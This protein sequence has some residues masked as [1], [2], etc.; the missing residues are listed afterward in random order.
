MHADDQ[1]R[2]RDSRPD[3]GILSLG[4]FNYYGNPAQKSVVAI[5]RVGFGAAMGE[6]V[7]ASHRIDV[8]ESVKIAENIHGVIVSK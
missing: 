3:D 7:H 8:R 2:R 5:L 4:T 6:L 1:K